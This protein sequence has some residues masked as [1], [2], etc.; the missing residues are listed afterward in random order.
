MDN[1]IVVR[2]S[3][4]L[5][6][7][8]IFY[9]ECG[10]GFPIVFLHGYPGRPQDFRWLSSNISAFRLIFLALPGLDISPLPNSSM[11][12][13][14]ERG[15]F[16]KSFCD[17]LSISQYHL[18]GHSM[19][20]MLA[21][22]L[23]SRYPNNIEKLIL[24]STVGPMPYKAYRRSRP[25]FVYRLIS[26]SIVQKMLM[27]GIRFAFHAMGFPKGVSDQAMI[28]VLACAN[29]I[30]FPEHASH[31]SQLSQPVLSLWCTDDPL[32]EA[33]SFQQLVDI[34][35]NCLSIS[36]PTGGHNPQKKHATEVAREIMG[37]CQKI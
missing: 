19:G 14:T 35:P 32:I 12:T 26:Y 22:Y 15:E 16:V 4:T 30:S 13:I 28:Y 20:G 33:N 31:L 25:D 6:G 36:Y 34:I 2:K 24:I 11:F 9:D 27:P 23:A 18:V 21:T 7:F 17:A 5:N 1:P 29:A 3:I 8:D 10:E 37:F